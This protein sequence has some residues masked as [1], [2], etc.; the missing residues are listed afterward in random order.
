MEPENWRP[1]VDATPE[2]EVTS[3][4]SGLAVLPN[5][6]YTGIVTA[7]GHQLRPNPFGLIDV[8][9]LNGLFLIEMEGPCTNYEWLTVVELNL[10]YWDGHVEEAVFTKTL[11]CPPRQTIIGS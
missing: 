2:F 1:V 11:E 3:D 10:A 4:E 7:T 6:G 9:G 8:V 5:R